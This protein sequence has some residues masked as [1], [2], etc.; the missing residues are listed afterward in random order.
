MV[1]TVGVVRRA[2]EVLPGVGV[3]TPVL[4][5][6]LPFAVVMVEDFQHLVLLRWYLQTYFERNFK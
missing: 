6:L 1:G 5:Q 2:D 4:G 3:V